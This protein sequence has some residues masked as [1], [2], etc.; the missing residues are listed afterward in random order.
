MNAYSEKVQLIKQLCNLLH[1]KVQYTLE[2]FLS[3]CNFKQLVRL[4][5]RLVKKRVT[6]D[7]EYIVVTNTKEKKSDHNKFSI[8]I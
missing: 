5:S 1:Y 4:T 3:S 6:I 2:F 8:R 7:I